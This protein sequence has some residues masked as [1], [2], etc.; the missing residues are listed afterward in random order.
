MTEHKTWC[1][2]YRQQ[3][4]GEVSLSNAGVATVRGGAGG[5]TKTTPRKVFCGCGA[6][7]GVYRYLAKANSRAREKA[8]GEQ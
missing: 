7:P 3:L 5:M 2:A 8:E 1:R 4:N 6:T